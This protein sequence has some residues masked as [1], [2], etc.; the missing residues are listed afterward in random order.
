MMNRLMVAVA[1]KGLFPLPL[2]IVRRHGPDG[3]TPTEAKLLSLNYRRKAV[4]R[5]W[6]AGIFFWGEDR[7]RG[8]RFQVSG[9]RATLEVLGEIDVN[10]FDNLKRKPPEPGTRP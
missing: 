3:H 10:S 8:F 2:W 5:Q 1:S 9:F 6:E 4:Y 7:S